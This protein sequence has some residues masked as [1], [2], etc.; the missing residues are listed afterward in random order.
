MCELFAL[1]SARPTTVR[2][3]LE[4]FS[5]HGG[6]TGPHKDG[7]GIAHDVDGDVRLL[8]ETDP[9]SESACV[10]FI[11]DHPFACSL[12]VSHIRKATQG[13][14][15]LQNCQPFAR[16]LGGRM[17][18][19]AHNGDLDTRVWR[20]RP[21]PGCA[22]PVGD[23][24]SELA[25]CVLLERLRPVWLVGLPALADRRRIVAEFAAELR[26]LGPAN[27]I[28]ADGDAL[29]AHGHKRTHGSSGIRPPG[30]HRLC[31]Q[32]RG[33]E[34]S[35]HVPGLSIDSAFAPEQWVVLFASVP[36]SAEPG[37]QPLAEGELVVARAG[38]LVDDQAP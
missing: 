18:V 21:T 17:H 26:A 32:C 13:G 38:R 19:F 29:F 14:A 2:Y 16:E 6:L 12:A 11:R 20:D 5:R 23:T 28:Y 30:L 24:D 7:W 33:E 25:F 4:E 3:S 35:L 10:R 36:L 1:S 9:A 27:F 8:K 15:M 34:A 22:R 37:W 31:R